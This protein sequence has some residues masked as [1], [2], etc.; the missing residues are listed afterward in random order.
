MA[1]IDN[2]LSFD[3]DS[4]TSKSPMSSGS[5]VGISSSG[6]P[7]IKYGFKCEIDCMMHFS[8]C[9]LLLWHTWM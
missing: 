7:D 1:V 8:S 3:G 4:E 2:P 5:S 9:G 6:I